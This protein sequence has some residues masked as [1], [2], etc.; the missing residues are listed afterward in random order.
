MYEVIGLLGSL[1]FAVCS[2]PLAYDSFKRRTAVGI[3]WSFVVIWFLA[4][5]F[6]AVY[7]V[8]VQKYVLLPN[9][10]SGGLGIAVVLY[11]KIRETVKGKRHGN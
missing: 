10:L 9:Y 7:A 2:W 11:I 4:A 8:G 1:L 3:K 6:S 5:L